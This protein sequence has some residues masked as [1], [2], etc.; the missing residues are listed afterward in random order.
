MVYDE[1]LQAGPQTTTNHLKGTIWSFNALLQ[2]EPNSLAPEP[3]LE[4]RIFPVRYPDGL[5]SRVSGATEFAIIDRE[6]LATRF[7]GRIKLL[8]YTMA[9]VRQLKPFIEWTNLQQRYLSASV[10]EITS[11]SG[12]VTRPISVRNHDLKRK[13]HPLL[14]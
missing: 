13:A 7:D 9:E 8:D 10:K 6:Y 12:G 11:V 1:L 5:T 3:L 2:T 14:R 4:A